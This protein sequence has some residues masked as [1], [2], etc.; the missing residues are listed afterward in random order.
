M[1]NNPPCC[2]GGFVTPGTHEHI[3]RAGGEG[4]LE[5][6]L[7]W[8]LAIYGAMVLVW[9]VVKRV[10]RK[11]QHLIPMNIVLIVQNAE[12]EIEGTLRCLMVNT[13]FGHRERQIVV[14]DIASADET[15]AIVEKMAEKH[16]CIDY[17]RFERD[18]DAFERIQTALLESG[19]VTC[20]YD[21]RR[22]DMLSRVAD[23]VTSLCQ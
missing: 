21:L 22:G 17:H 23:D 13:A 5:A 7:F 1:P 4:V 15:Q 9:Q 18:S 16:Q 20:I 11:D 6:L 19:K 8:S 14:C 3:L 2:H 12:R 10:T